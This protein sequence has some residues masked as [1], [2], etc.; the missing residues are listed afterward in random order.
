MASHSTLKLSALASAVA[1][2]AGCAATSAPAPQ[3][4]T[5]ATASSQADSFIEVENAGYMKGVD[6]VGVMSCNVMFGMTSAASASTS[7][8]FRAG[9][10]RAIGTVTR[11]DVKVSV[12]YSAA[13][14]SEEALQGIAT[15]LC[16][17][18]ETQLTQAG[19][20]VVPHEIIK[21]N[22]YYRNI[23][24]QG[25]TA[26]FEYKG[27]GETRYLVMAR[28][29]ETI[30]DPQY[31]GGMSGFAQSFKGIGGDNAEQ[32]EDY[33]MKDLK[34]TGVNINLLVDFAALES[35]GDSSWG[36]FSN[37]DTA[38]VEGKVQLAVGGDL[39]FQPL[40]HQDCWNEW[41]KEKCMVKLHH[42]PVFASK[43]FVASNAQFYSS[44]DDVTSTGD[45]VYSGVTQVL[46][47]LSALGG[48]SSSIG[49]D[50]TRYQVN[51]IP[52]TYQAETE[53]LAG[54][55]VAMAASKAASQK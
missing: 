54:G 52:A 39:R 50:I 16:N 5:K 9:R 12:T 55:L 32:L 17:D 1:L 30:Y 27:K 21:A 45:K 4:D 23:H 43:H 36:G 51:I 20:E 53:R 47:A 24:A 13:G 15:Q 14:I 7:G 33:L 3:F 37:K 41:G 48:T 34:M 25:R 35:D 38:Q 26:A 22:E 18:A 10:T 42:Q 49:R 8:G 31:A 40:A 28:P 11:S 6:R 19:F 44:I 46:G 29:G 2:I